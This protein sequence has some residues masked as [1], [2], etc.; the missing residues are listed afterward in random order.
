MPASS[1]VTG[2]VAGL[3]AALPMT[4]AMEVMHRF[5]H[6]TSAIPY[7]PEKLPKS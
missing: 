5:C 2:A 4:L 7:R 1:L 6:S 3:G